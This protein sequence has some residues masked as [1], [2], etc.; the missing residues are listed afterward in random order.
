MPPCVLSSS[1]IFSGLMN[2]QQRPCV[3]DT[4]QMNVFLLKKIQERV[5]AERASADEV[6][7]ETF[8]LGLSNPKCT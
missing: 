7:S 2:S 6:L 5:P 3:A 4:V 1:G 8:Q